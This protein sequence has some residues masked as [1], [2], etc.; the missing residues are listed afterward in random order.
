MRK[1]ENGGKRKEV[2]LAERLA[3]LVRRWEGGQSRAERLMGDKGEGRR[4]G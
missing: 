3:T 1:E 2:R 4:R